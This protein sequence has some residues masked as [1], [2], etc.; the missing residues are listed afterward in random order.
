MDGGGTE[1]SVLGVTAVEYLQKG[2]EVREEGIQRVKSYVARS[3]SWGRRYIRLSAS[4]S[5][6]LYGFR[7]SGSDVCM[8]R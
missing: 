2:V 6:I 3:S 8:P 1:S 5:M 4:R 7:R